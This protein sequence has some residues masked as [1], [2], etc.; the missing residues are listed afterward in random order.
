MWVEVLAFLLLLVMGYFVP[1]QFVEL[2]DKVELLKNILTFIGEC[3]KWLDYRNHLDENVRILRRRKEA[4]CSR[5]DEVNEE[6]D[7]AELKS[8]TTRKSEVAYWLEN[9]QI[10][11]SDVARIMQGFERMN[12]LKRAWQGSQVE[13]KIKEVD[14]LYKEGRFDGLVLKSLRTSVDA[15]LTKPLLDTQQR[16]VERI[17]ECVMN[18]DD[19]LIIGVTGEQGIGKTSIIEHIYN[20]LIDSNFDC[21]YFVTIS[22]E[23]SIRKLQNDIAKEIGLGFVDEEDERKRA[24]MLHKGLRRKKSVLILDGLPMHVSLE[25]IGIST[26]MNGC[27]LILTSRLSAVCR[28]MGCK[29][30]IEVTPL[31]LDEAETLFMKEVGLNDQCDPE[32]KNIAK[33]IVKECAGLPFSIVNTAERLMGVDDI[34]EWRTTLNELKEHGPIH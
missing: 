34:Y 13:K 31:P 7:T 6:L 32:I 10:L 14:K 25:K 29:Q 15:L 5:R 19:A 21:V 20:R 16:E 2:G 4:L 23:Y 1:T 9:V 30:P 18:D 17:W 27:K 24:A 3:P 33:Q 22:E 8:R 12:F 28:R 11:E 26:Q